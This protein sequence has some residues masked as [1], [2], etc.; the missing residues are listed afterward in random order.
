MTCIVGLVKDGT[1]WL[2]GDSAGVG[3]WDLTIRADAKVFTNGPFLMGFTTSFRMGQILRYA[4]DVPDQS[5]K[6]DDFAF[7]VTTFVDAVRGALKR[8][9]YAKKENE[10]E[11]GGQFLVGYKGVLYEIG[12]DYQVALPTH[13]F[14]AV[15]CGDQVA[16]GS[17]YSTMGQPPRDRVVRALEAAEQF[18]AG[19]RAPFHVLELGRT[20]A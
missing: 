8:G 11:S 4:L 16:H 6:Q 7:M 10:H 2:G 12:G 18:S 20:D 14:A 9:G 5:H 19:V 15:G 13:G 3:G 17:L 1:V